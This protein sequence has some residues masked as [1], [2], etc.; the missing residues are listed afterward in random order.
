MSWTIEHYPTRWID[1]WPLP[2]GRR[3]TVRPVLP[4]DA[5]L[6]QA[7][8][9]ALSPAS[10][11]QR[12]FVPIRELPQGW[13]ERLT[14]IDYHRQQ[15]FIVETF[16]GDQALAVAEARYVVDASGEEAEFA[17]VVADDWRQLGRSTMRC[18]R[19][20]TAWGFACSAIRTAARRCCVSSAR[21][22]RRTR[23]TRGP[24]HRPFQRRG[25]GQRH[26]LD[27]FVEQRAPLVGA[28][29]AADAA[30]LDLAVVDAARLLGQ[31]LAHVLRNARKAAQLRHQARET[32]GSRSGGRDGAR[33]LHLTRC[34]Q[35]CRGGLAGLDVGR[36][37]QAADLG[38]AADRAVHQAVR[39]LRLE[40][41][42]G[43]EP[44]FEAV[45]I[46]AV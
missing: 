5:E 40:G 31:A 37:R 14:Q 19:W 33:G 9:R 4:Q 39:E 7:M 3:V 25:D 10:R 27:A 22:R 42:G 6:E 20:R 29:L 23:P 45:C 32:F 2:D 15:A 44:A 46:A 16:V 17:V 13:L 30:G 26:D 21:C 18:V 28:G 1:V 41:C 8:V 12:F 24:L 35:P 36:A 38:G 11:Y 34:G 43:T